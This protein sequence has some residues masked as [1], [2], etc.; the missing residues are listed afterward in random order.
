MANAGTT[1]V[2]SANPSASNQELPKND[3]ETSVIVFK[4]TSA[5][6]LTCFEGLDHW[7]GGS[8]IA[9]EGCFSPSICLDLQAHLQER[10]TLKQ[11]RRISL[12]IAHAS[13]VQ[14]IPDKDDR[15][16][17]ESCFASKE[18]VAGAQEKV[19]RGRLPMLWK[20]DLPSLTPEMH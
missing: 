6:S 17:V 3:V 9:L 18:N 12:S 8:C 19:L 10:S 20:D 14:D 4:I 15:C 1:S 7:S 16:D 5:Q 2:K 11:D 13:S